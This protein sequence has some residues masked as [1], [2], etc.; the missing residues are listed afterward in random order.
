MVHLDPQHSGR[1]AVHT[2]QKG[3]ARVTRRSRSILAAGAVLLMMS[4]SCSRGTGAGGDA[5]PRPDSSLA[6][7]V[8][9]LADSARTVLLPVEPP[10]D[11]WIAKVTPSRPAPPDPPLPEAMP[12]VPEE[13]PPPPALEIDP[14]LKPPIPRRTLCA[15]VPEGTS[16]PAIVVLDVQVG[17]D[18]RVTDVVWAGGSGDP[19]LV[20]AAMDC[21]RSMTFYPALRGAEPVPVWCRQRFDFGR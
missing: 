16:R 17:A 21:A 3:P 11:V 5:P 8:E 18:G 15:A 14:G 4:T 20:D 13:T 9:W 19:A 1:R 6:I 7:P 12:S 10:P 2:V